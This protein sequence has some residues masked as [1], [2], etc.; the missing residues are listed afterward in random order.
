MATV[1]V[2]VFRYYLGSK[3]LQYPKPQSYMGI[4]SLKYTS[5]VQERKLIPSAVVDEIL[6]LNYL[7][8]EL[9]KH[10]EKLYA[11]QEKF[12]LST[13]ELQVFIMTTAC[14]E[15]LTLLWILEHQ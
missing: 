4:G 11:K 9:Y 3:F 10:A 13:M 15:F 7:D 14:L 6:S 5:F 12:L 1:M 8:V 2:N